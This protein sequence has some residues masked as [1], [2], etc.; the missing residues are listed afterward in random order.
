LP[1]FAPIERGEVV[2]AAPEA[3]W[4]RRLH[5]LVS[6]ARSDE[7]SRLL[8]VEGALEGQLDITFL[9]DPLDW[10]AYDV[11]S[12]FDAADSQ[13]D[14]AGVVSLTTLVAQLRLYRALRGDVDEALLERLVREYLEEEPGRR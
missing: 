6:L 5:D 3:L 10:I 11:A 8:G 13:R 2:R 14:S 9:D 7:A 1:A 12:A 4:V